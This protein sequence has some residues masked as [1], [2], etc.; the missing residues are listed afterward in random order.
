MNA[1]G[2]RS[3]FFVFHFE[4][5]KGMAVWV[6]ALLKTLILTN[7]CKRL[8]LQLYF[9]L[10]NFPNKIALVIWEELQLNL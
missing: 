10:G 8:L 3:L 4:I 1:L 7:I 2:T 9:M 6:Y 5:E